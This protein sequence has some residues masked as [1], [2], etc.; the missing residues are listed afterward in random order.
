MNVV[1]RINGNDAPT[2]E[3]LLKYSKWLLRMNRRRGAAAIEPEELVSEAVCS[4][5]K[6]MADAMKVIRG[7]VIEEVRKLTASQQQHALGM[8]SGRFDGGEK[9]CSRCRE[10]KPYS[11]FYSKTCHKSGMLYYESRCKVCRVIV[12]VESRRR[13]RQAKQQNA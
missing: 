8:C 4:E 11:A 5:P 9:V 12:N 1:Q 10:A 2:Y 13:I 6:T 3:A 7:F